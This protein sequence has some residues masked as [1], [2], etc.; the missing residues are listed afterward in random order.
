MEKKKFAEERKKKLE[1]LQKTTR[2]LAIASIK[3]KVIQC[4]NYC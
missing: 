4:M 1:Q 3:P 2:E